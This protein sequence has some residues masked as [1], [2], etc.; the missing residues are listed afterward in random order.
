MGRPK[1]NT[2]RIRKNFTKARKQEFL[3]RFRATFNISR[4]CRD[5]GMSTASIYD[6]IRSDPEFAAELETYR[7]DMQHMAEDVVEQ[8][9]RDGDRDMAKFV[10]SKLSAKW[11]DKVDVTAR[12]DHVVIR[13]GGE[14]E[15][16]C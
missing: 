4:V 2:C 13:F 15:T 3:A 6:H 1:D 16:D 11:R 8:A 9:L 10:L 12:I 14:D 5:M 7:D